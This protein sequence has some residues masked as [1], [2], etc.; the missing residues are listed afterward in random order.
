[1]YKLFLALFLIT[2]SSNAKEIQPFSKFVSAGFVN[3]FVI[4]NNSL[5]VGND[6]G[7]VDIFDIET[8]K[9]KKQIILPPLTSSM[10]KII[11]ADILSVDYLN[12]KTLILSVGKDSYRNVWIYENDELKQIINEDKK[13]TIKKAKFVNDEQL[14]LGTLDSDIMF[15]DMSENYNLYNTHISD[16]AMGD[17]VLSDDKNTMVLADESGAVNIIDVKSSNILKTHKSQN[18]DNIFRVAYSNGSIITAGQDRRVG[19]YPKNQKPYYIK[20]DFLVFCVALSPNGRTG[21]YSRG[22]EADLQIFDIYTKTQHTLLV[23][24]DG[25]VNKILFRKKDEIF[26]SD[27]TN[28]VFRWKLN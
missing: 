3:D 14:M 23:G 18:V 28:T 20:S 25:V 22:E 7:S 12:G 15:Y 26:S 2:T 19:V 1:M 5:H 24:H 8:T 13:L 6:A 4:A 27:R 16:S 10:G 9:I 21:I 17:M 11:P